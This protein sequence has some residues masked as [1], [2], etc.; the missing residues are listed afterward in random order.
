[1]GDASKVS[2]SGSGPKDSVTE[3]AEESFVRERPVDIERGTVL[4]GRYQIEEVIGK[5]GSG[6]VL[7]AFDRTAQALVALKVLKPELASDA[8]WSKR[9]SREL[10]LGRPVQHSNV[11]RI[12]DIGEADGHRFLTMELATAGTL[13]DQLKRGES[14]ARPLPERLADAEAIIAGL[15]AIHAVGIVHRD[16]KPDNLLRMEDRRL[17][18]SDFGLATDTANAPG[19][20]VLIGTPHYMAPEVLAGEPATTRSDVWALGVV[21]HEIF[22]GRRPERRAVSFD[23]ST[24]PH[25]RPDSPVERAMLDLCEQCLADAPLDRPADAGV[26]ATLFLAA[27][28]S[29]GILRRRRSRRYLAGVAIGLVAA[30]LAGAFSLRNSRRSRATVGTYATSDT[31]RLEPTGKAADWSK[32]AVAVTEVPGHVHCFSIVDDKTARLVWGTPRRAEDINIATGERRPAPLAPE[33]YSVGCPELSPQKNALLFSAQQAAGATELRLWD[34]KEGH[35][36]TTVTPGSDP[37]W[38]GNGEE[39]LYNVDATHAA[40]FSLPTMSLT[41]LPD[42]HP[43]SHQTILGKAVQLATESMALLL[44][45]DGADVAVALYQGRTTEYRGAFIVPAGRRIQF[46][47]PDDN[48]LVSYQLSGTVS[49]LAALDWHKGSYRNLG[50]LPGLDLV[51]ARRSGDQTIL[52]GRHI[53]ND[54]WFYDGSSRRALTSDGETYSAAISSDGQLLLSKRGDDG[55][56]SIWSQGRDGQL[57]RVTAGPADVGPDFSSDGRWWVYADYAQKSIVL[58]SVAESTCRTLRRDSQLPTWPKVSA[59][60]TKVAY[61][62]QTNVPRL[63]IV[64]V[65]DGRVQRSWDAYYQ[66]PPV[67]SSPTTIW[68]FEAL[69]GHYFWAERSA[70]SGERT[71]SRI[72]IPGNGAAPSEIQCWPAG[73]GRDSP[74]FQR[75]RV[76][77][78]ETAKLL[79]LPA[80]STG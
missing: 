78:R 62:T 32:A 5:G 57:K 4:A 71:G 28:S 61:L 39:F 50:M 48:V 38:L 29:P 18:L 2:S 3:V 51:G 33:T 52:L 73:V 69:A 58:C 53:S 36:A 43:G 46:S 76:E 77:T 75:V 47:D 66:C 19:V 68:S 25:P 34:L 56:V 13:R 67:W 35:P 37:Q 14:A 44:S 60:G 11:C 9:F 23:G 70:M 42:P 8:K 59:D 63:T 54:A 65:D 45:I 12:F 79:R 27:R 22:F 72:E 6:V 30:A 74:F 41:L 7:R 40:I 21:L 10:R 31:I 26:A 1:M 64:S 80:I 49:T 20:T 16:F 15:A 55:R 24:R 17:V